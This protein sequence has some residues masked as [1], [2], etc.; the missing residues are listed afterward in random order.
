MEKDRYL[1]SSLDS[2]LSLVEL[3]SHHEALTL[4]EITKLTDYDKS[5]IFRMLYTLCKNQLVEKTEDGYYRLGLKF[6]YYSSK[7]QSY[8][9]IVSASRPYMCELGKRLNTPIHMGRLSGNRIITIHIEDHVSGPHVTG[10]VGMNAAAH[11]TAMGRVLLAHLS[12]AELAALADTLTFKRYSERSVTNMRELRLILRE[13][14]ENGYGLDMDDRYQGFGALAVPVFDHDGVCTTSI[15][16]VTVS[17]VI[18]ERKGE[19]VAAL[20]DTAVRISAC[21]SGRPVP[22]AQV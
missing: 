19:Y 5:S 15:S 9:D 6:L 10:R 14:R 17:Q 7:V 1:L 18:R 12:D 20:K 21:L 13:V 2:A 4:A 8:L 11:T 3:L 22:P 16:V